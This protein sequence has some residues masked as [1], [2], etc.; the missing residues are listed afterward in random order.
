[1]RRLFFTLLGASLVFSGCTG[2]RW[3]SGV[4]GEMRSVSVPVFR[5]ESRIPGLGNMVT[6]ELLH[7]F[8]R[9][10]TFAV[11]AV[12]KGAVEIQG[13]VVSCSA[14]TLSYDRRS[15][16][17]NREA[18]LMITVKVSV[19]DRLTSKVLVNDRSYSATVSFVS[20]DDIV[21]GEREAA[22]RLAEDFA[23]Q[24]VDDLVNLK[25]E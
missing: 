15:G 25:W 20:T 2:Y 10:G 5:N 3:T 11:A 7:E 13:E 22:N 12:G 4:P 17:R 1:M 18:G 16:M 9:E 19:I 23:R 24:V 21:T 14:S 8:G 6:R